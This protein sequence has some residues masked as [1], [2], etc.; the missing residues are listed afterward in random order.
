[1]KH[2]IRKYW[3]ETLLITLLVSL[4]IGFC[5]WAI[6]SDIQHDKW[7]N[8]LTAEEKAEYDAEQEAIR[9]SNIHRYEVVGVSQYVR[10][11]TNN[12]GGIIDTDICYAFQ[13]LDGNNLKTVENFEHLEYGLTK[14]IVGDSNM[15]IVDTNGIDDYRYLQLTKE[16]LQNIKVGEKQ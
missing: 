15:Y 9:Q 1:M 3:F 16:T 8:S 7:Y 10:N 2:F 4:F 13:Y 14:I 6:V 5:A 12:F 11:Q